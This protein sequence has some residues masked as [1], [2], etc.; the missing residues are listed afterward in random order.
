MV[1]K[2]NRPKATTHEGWSKKVTKYKVKLENF[3]YRTLY[4]MNLNSPNINL[5]SFVAIEVLVISYKEAK[6]SN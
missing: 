5:I 1:H 2:N 3:S 4:K 6:I